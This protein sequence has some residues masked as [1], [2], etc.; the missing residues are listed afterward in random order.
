[1]KTFGKR[2]LCRALAPLA[3]A[4]LA[5]AATAQDTMVGYVSP[6]ASQ[7]GQAMAN[8]IME[9]MAGELGWD[10]R[11]LDA[12]LSPDRQVSHV[13]TLVTLGGD[14]ISS[15]SLD[16]NA[17]AAA[18]TRANEAGV[19]VIGVNS[20]GP[21]VTMTVWWE[22]NLCVDGG[23]YDV[24][25]A[26]IKDRRPDAKVIVMGG[27]PVPSIQQNTRCFEAAAKAAGFEVLAQVDNTKDSTA[28]AATIAA[29]LLVRHPDADVFW[30]YNDSSA[31]GISA[32][33]MASGKGVYGGDSTDGVMIFG[34]NGD[35]EAIAAIREGRIT[36]SWDPDV[37]GMAAAIVLGM[38]S[39]LDA[40][41]D[42][43]DDLIV[44]AKLL[45][46]DNI[47]DYVPTMDRGYTIDTVPLLK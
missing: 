25:A 17:V 34:M 7:P 35:E 38:K 43:Q 23:A 22:T 15:W 11:M 30:A 32:A 33:V 1:M 10:Y 19:R 6:I 14:V 41:G 2:A 18:Y 28:N 42:A 9:T 12:N 47:A 46:A 44:K 27:P 24:Q 40:P 26:W 16:P 5:G 31:L 21:G 20:E 29:D 8:E 37:Y 45:T 39:L 4:G 13:D 36:G 3:L